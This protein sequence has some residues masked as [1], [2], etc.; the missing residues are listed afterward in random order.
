M[1]SDSLE[2]LLIRFLPSIDRLDTFRSS[3]VSF[4]AVL[5]CLYLLTFVILALLRIVTGISIHRI[6]YLSLHRL[7]FSPR[8]YVRLKINKIGLSIHRP[9]FTRHGW[10][11]LYMRGFELEL[12]PKLF[13]ESHTKKSKVKTTTPISEHDKKPEATALLNILKFFLNFGKYLDFN[14]RNTSV[15][16]T[17]VSTLII[18]NVFSKVDL[19][20]I[21]AREADTSKFIGTLNNRQYK[22]GETAAS[23]RIIVQDV[24]YTTLS[25]NTESENE[26]I[27]FLAVDIKAIVDKSDVSVKDMSLSCK[28]GSIDIRCDQ[29]ITLAT[30]L[31][32][33]VSDLSEKPSAQ[34]GSPSSLSKI[35]KAIYL[36]NNVELKVTTIDVHRIPLQ[37]LTSP[38]NPTIAATFTMAMKDFSLDL[39]RL[40]NKN[41]AFR[42]LFPDEDAAHQAILT[43]S[44]F[45]LGINTEGINEEIIYIPHVTIISKTNIFSKIVKN[46]DIQE[47]VKVRNETILRANVNITTPSVT[48]ESHHVGLLSGPFLK[49]KSKEHSST[50]TKESSAKSKFQRL[51]PRATVKLTIDEPAVRILVKKSKSFSV[52]L[53]NSKLVL[54]STS[55][56]VLLNCKKLYCDFGSSHTEVESDLNYKLNASLQL[57]GVDSLFRSNTGQQFEFSN[58][59][60]FAVQVSAAVNPSLAVEIHGQWNQPRVLA[61]NSEILYGLQDVVYHLKK[62]RGTPTHTHPSEPKDFFLKRLPWWLTTLKLDLSDVTFALAADEVDNRF[63]TH[64]GL[65]LCVA[66]LV[67]EYSD[68]QDKAS[69]EARNQPGVGRRLALGIEGLT[70]HKVIGSGS[71]QSTILDMER[72]AVILTTEY[73]SIGSLVHCQTVLP[74]LSLELDVNVFYLVSICVS[75]VRNTLMLSSNTVREKKEKPPQ[76]EFVKFSLES[77][78]IN[79]K[80]NLP[81]ETRLMIEGNGLKLSITRDQPMEIVAR[82]IRAYTSHPSVKNAWTRLFSTQNLQVDFKDSLAHIGKPAPA[83]T[84]EQILVSTDG[85]RLNLTHGLVVYRL[86]DN[87]IIS[88][89]IAATLLHRALHDDPEYVKK[90]KEKKVMPNVPKIR[91]KSKSLLI[92]FEDD[93]FEAK[94]NLIFQVGQREQQKRLEKEALFEAKVKAMMTKSA[95]EKKQNHSENLVSPAM[96]APDLLHPRT[97]QPIEKRSHDHDAHLH[98]KTLRGKSERTNTFRSFKRSNAFYTSEN[99]TSRTSSTNPGREAK[100]DGVMED[101]EM[102]NDSSSVSIPQAREQLNQY[103]STNWILE[104]NQAEANLKASIREQIKS[105][106]MNDTIDPDFLSQERI[107]DYSPFPFLFFMHITD[108]D[109]FIAKPSLTEDGLRD[110]LY[111][112]GKGQPRDTRYSVLMPLY[113][114]LTCGSLRLQLRD[115]P[116]PFL[117]FPELHASQ[118]KDIPNIQIEGVFC[119]AETLSV[120][121]SNMRQVFVSVD[122]LDKAHPASNALNPFMVQIN[123]TVASVKMFTDLQFQI[124]TLNPSMITWCVSMQP[125]IQSFMQVFDLLSKPP[126]D[127]SEKLGFWDKI[128]S[129][130]HARLT[131]KW[132]KGNVHFQL[133]GSSNPYRLVGKSAGFVMC[134]KNNVVVSCNGTLDPKEFITV[135]SDDFIMG[136][137]DYSVQE[138]GYLKSSINKTGGLVSRSNTDDNIVF[139][140]VVMKLS[141][142]V[143]WTGGLLFERDVKEEPSVRTFNFRPHYEVV[144]ANPKYI[145]DKDNYDAYRGFRSD[146]LH[147]A[148]GVTSVRPEHMSED[149]YLK[150]SYNSIHLTPKVFAHF[151]KWFHLFNSAL[152]LPVRAGPLFHSGSV[153]K[154]KK[155]GQHLFTIKYQIQLMPLFINHSYVHKSYLPDEHS[156]TGLKAKIDKFFVDMHQRRARVDSSSGK[157]WKMGLNIAEMDVVSTDLRV[158][159]ASFKEKSLKQNLANRLGVSV[160]PGSSVTNESNVGSHQ[161]SSMGG[162]KIQISDSDFSWID[163]DDY[164]EL[165]ECEPGR[166]SPRITVFPLIYTPRWAYFRQT[167]PAESEDVSITPFG[168]EPSHKCLIGK[169]LVDDIHTKLLQDRV[170]ELEEQL[171]TK[172]T[173][174]ESLQKDFT[175][176]SDTVDISE[177][178]FKVKDEIA[179]MRER[180]KKILSLQEVNNDMRDDMQVSMEQSAQRIARI[181]SHK[182]QT[183]FAPEELDDGASISSDSTDASLDEAG[184][185]SFGNRFI[186]HSVQIKWDMSVRNAIFAYL[187][188]VVERKSTSYFL[189]QRAVRYLDDLMEKQNSMNEDDGSTREQMTSEFL[190]DIV[191]TL[192]SSTSRADLS[193]P[194]GLDDIRTTENDNYS[195]NDQYL[196]KFVSPQ[197]QLVAE[198]NPDYCVLLTSENIEMKIIA[199]NDKERDEEDGSKLVETRYGVS[200]QDAQFFVISQ[201]QVKSGAFTLFSSNS[202]GCSKGGMWPPWLSIDCCYDSR[203]LKSALIIDRTSVNMRYDQPNPL[204]MQSANKAGELKNMCTAAL[205][206]DKDHRQNR[207]GVD[208]PKVVATFDSKQFFALYTITMNLL[209]YKEPMVKERS[210]RLDKVLL[211]TD[212]TNLENAAKRVIQLQDDV[213]NF[214]ELRNE[215]MVRSSEL[216]SQMIE[217]LVKIEVE[218]SHA[219]L[220]LFVMMEAIKAGMQKVSRD[221]DTAQLLKWA[222]GADQVIWHVLDENREPFLDVG[223]ANVSFN[224]VEG[225]DGFNTNSIEIMMMQGFNLVSET[226]YPEVFSPYLSAGDVYDEATPFMSAQWTMLDPIGGI[227]IVQQ[228][229]IKLK[230]TKVEIDSTTWDMIFDYIFPKNG[231]SSMRVESPFAV[232]PALDRKI[233]ESGYETGESS[234]DEDTSDDYDTS[235]YAESESSNMDGKSTHRTLRKLIPDNASSLFSSSSSTMSGFSSSSQGR[236][237]KSGPLTK[238]KT[239]PPHSRRKRW[240]SKKS[241]NDDISL[242][243]NRASNYLSIVEISLEAPTL[244]VSYK[245]DGS[246]SILD[247]HEF[248][249][250]LPALAYKNKTWS[251]MDIVLQLKKDVTKILFHHM[252][253]LL[254]NK[255]K[256]HNKLKT[257]MQLRQLTEYTG[258]MLVS[259]LIYNSRSQNDSN[260]RYNPYFASQGSAGN[261]SLSMSP[262]EDSDSGASTPTRRMEKFRTRADTIIASA[263]PMLN[264]PNN[265]GDANQSRPSLGSGSL[266]PSSSRK[267]WGTVGNSPAGAG[268]DEETVDDH[269]GESKSK[270]FLKKLLNKPLK[271]DVEQ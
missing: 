36:F 271:E 209:I 211:A 137:P 249:L 7:D 136:V 42:I 59:N 55:G 54:E 214:E 269:E 18:G 109:W 153:A 204:R 80:A 29:L 24:L 21:D 115:Y 57:D 82:F 186:V 128:R 221:D 50:S 268:Q 190:G 187:H 20:N 93:L 258:Y 196:V 161:S 180:I 51:W 122:P 165:G 88:L 81:D 110:F 120:E 37:T 102:A 145:K 142:R 220:E 65:K 12:D 199:I 183:Q 73:D 243:L 44:S 236:S 131:L 47:T 105:D 168:N 108:M 123:R 14:A 225:G 201:E 251:N 228:F 144:L 34:P 143:K 210:E 100:S 99:G 62:S 78:M 205:V 127:P 72:F 151:F 125:A 64:R 242:M 262:R 247:I 13:R 152:S 35:S 17:G 70:C 126:I 178:I 202:Y 48:I 156:C 104:Y 148:I 171:K 264:I 157:R 244:C 255:F 66:K 181:M 160:S 133:K 91:I 233:P 74:T 230:P 207:I 246:H 241:D 90:I 56:M 111:D 237:E 49:P 174:L 22:Q 259:D 38:N 172:E 231:D 179:I 226:F 85:L 84:N 52:P 270:R 96:S 30:S 238:S 140:K 106:F 256:R 69:S 3:L 197:I 60:S 252:G 150:H 9:T 213:R 95:E 138:R 114:N 67:L 173:M 116:L 129:V 10:L 118:K 130:F 103:F 154:P 92:S 124:N 112:V 164:T 27:D 97:D 101:S 58:C 71:D 188:R 132:P 94:L 41:P 53:P 45:M 253:K 266:T 169:E 193:N 147:M 232:Q 194:D 219:T 43:G 203:P 212:F 167:G 135:C 182:R 224:R 257:T 260:E 25:L 215:Y 2:A 239:K 33:M 163:S 119:I 1:P 32:E 166:D 222:I 245:G 46:Q 176:I 63:A 98:A 206:R 170:E 40:N 192:K 198:Q 87:L 28:L 177:R 86:T 19:R 16:L 195:A 250:S 113:N 240:R 208:F 76:K 15:T 185:T 61:L 8:P 5:V 79:L 227:P 261:S 162:A 191:Q 223:L 149:M 218:Q 267:S 83:N 263:K 68:S 89:K 159:T 139:Q 234:N 248:V 189:T 31:K 39:H 23:L 155:F 11:G 265:S 184:G 158:L 75:L 77:S 229:D 121:E 6:G 216:N 117:Y 200:L 134:W 4:T 141:G 107:V 217:D 175:H 235:S 26:F 146:Y 254:N